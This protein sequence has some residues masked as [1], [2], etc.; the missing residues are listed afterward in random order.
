MSLTLECPTQTCSW[1]DRLET[2]VSEELLPSAGATAARA[3][4]LRIMPFE[5][6]SRKP[7]RAPSCASWQSV[8]PMFGAS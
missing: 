5:M 6:L 7:R 3:L 2:S 8:S 4:I 1:L